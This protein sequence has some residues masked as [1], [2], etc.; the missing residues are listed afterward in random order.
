MWDEEA[1]TEAAAEELECAMSAVAVVPQPHRAPLEAREKAKSGRQRA[2]NSE[3]VEDTK[4]PPA[5]ASRDRPSLHRKRNR[6]ESW[7]AATEYCL[8]P[9]LS[10]STAH[11]PRPPILA[12]EREDGEE[13]GRKRYPRLETTAP[14]PSS[15]PAA[16]RRDGEEGSGECTSLGVVPTTGVQG[17][18][19]PMEGPLSPSMECATVSHN[20]WEKASESLVG[21]W[22]EELLTAYYADPTTATSLWRSRGNEEE[23]YLQDIYCYPDH[24]KDDEYDSN[25][26][27]F[28]GND[29]PQEEDEEMENE[30]PDREEDEWEVG[31]EESDVSDEW[32]DSCCSAGHTRERRDEWEKRVVHAYHSRYSLDREE[33]QENAYLPGYEDEE[34]L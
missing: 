3:E 1:N 8:H 31:E 2:S 18:F 9:S 11:V 4:V 33:E 21:E 15:S 16:C 29:Y 17:P 5:G 26:E 22:C 12:E 13:E 10:F 23:E 14:P 20:F 19:M 27:D 34:G 7:K 25:A 24:R 30:M 28:E 6:K 32:E